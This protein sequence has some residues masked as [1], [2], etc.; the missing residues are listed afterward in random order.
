MAMSKYEKTVVALLSIIAISGTVTAVEVV[1]MA[2]EGF[3]VELTEPEAQDV[4]N[5]GAVAVPEMIEEGE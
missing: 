4:I 5:A 2:R 3:E 1:R